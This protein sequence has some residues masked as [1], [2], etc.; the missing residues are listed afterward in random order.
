[1][2]S[3]P[4][5]A[6]R[7]ERGDVGPVET[8]LARRK[9]RRPWLACRGA[10]RAAA[11]TAGSPRPSATSSTS[12]KPRSASQSSTPRTRISGTDAPLVTP[13][14]VDAV[15]P[16]R[17]R[18]RRRRR[19]G[20]TR[21]RR[22][23]APPRPAARSSTSCVDPTTMHQVGLPARSASPRPGGSAWRSR[24]RRSADRAA[25]GTAR[26]ARRTVSSVSSTDSV[27]C[28]SQAT[29]AGSRTSTAATSSG[30]STRCDVVGRLARGA[31]DLLVALVADQQDVEVLGGEPRGLVVHLGDQRAGRV[32][33]AQVAR[34]PPP[35]G[36]TG[37]TPCA[38]KTT[39]APSGTSSVSSTK[40]APRASR[41]ATTCL[42]WTIC[43]RT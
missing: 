21:G 8:P 40:I 26:A 34:P 2:S 29:F 13:T 1:M 16:A 10:A 17:R 32:D 36:P 31:D 15:E 39:I 24:C 11:R 12:A 14:V 41:S 20:T 3:S 37:A 27:V 18:S 43:L 25:A 23:R 19:P 4:R 9:R 28:D 7:A 35:R 42:L 5:Y 33:R 38:E 6:G 30:P 22:P